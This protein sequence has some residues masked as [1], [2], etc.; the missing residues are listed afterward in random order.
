MIFGLLLCTVFAFGQKY[1]NGK[2]PTGDKS[3]IGSDVLRKGTKPNQ[4][5]MTLGDSTVKYVDAD[6]AVTVGG[7]WGVEGNTTGA[8]KKLGTVDNQDISI[9]TNNTEKILIKSADTY[10]GTGTG[11][12]GAPRLNLGT[13]TFTVDDAAINIHRE[14]TGASLFSHGIRD[15]STFN[16]TTTGAYASFDAQ[17]IINGSEHL[18]HVNGH[19]TRIVF[20]NSGGA[21][22]V[23][24][25]TALFTHNGGT[26]TTGYGYHAA[27]LAGSGTFTNYYG[28][29]ME[30]Q[31]APGAYFLY[32]GGTSPSY[33]GGT[34]QTGSDILCGGTVNSTNL[35]S[36]S[37]FNSAGAGIGAKTSA[38]AGFYQTLFGHNA[39]TNM[40]S[41][42]NF[43]NTALGS[44]AGF[45]TTSGSSNTY[46]G[47]YAG[48]SGN[49]SGNVFLGK[50]AGFWETGSNKLI[51]DN[52][53]RTDEPSQR[54]QALIYGE[55]DATTTNQ[56][57]KVNGKFSSMIYESG[58]D[59]TTSD[60][61]SMYSAVW[62]NTTSGNVYLW[63][64]NHGSM[65][66]VQ[67]Q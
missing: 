27:A 66:K 31:T 5:L 16:S 30:P 24:G 28:F 43:F 22:A 65:I 7:G 59:P 12:T 39:G 29:F 11:T 56:I 52:V 44:A 25:H 21:D 33:M 17:P 37:G 41:A 45:T 67:I 2:V 42:S 46:V 1:S 38:T 57:V 9:I 50:Q 8:K 20:N 51:V 53:Q 26:I 40:T 62:K 4:I 10:S 55:F 6:T 54:T 36:N 60:I 18:N 19:Q 64:N 3:R 35:W 23:Y 49:G 14:I 58:S 34:L 32:S 47:S 13:G 63:V 61:P 48:Y 15:E